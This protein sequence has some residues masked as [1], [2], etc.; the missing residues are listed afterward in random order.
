MFQKPLLGDFKIDLSKADNIPV[1]IIQ[2]VENLAVRIEGIR[3]DKT[4]W[5]KGKN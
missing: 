1:I 4:R 5:Y 3:R 2:K